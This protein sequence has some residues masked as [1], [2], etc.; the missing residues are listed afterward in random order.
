MTGLTY[1]HSNFKK[2]IYEKRKDVNLNKILFLQNLQLF[3]FQSVSML[4]M[5][6]PFMYNV[7]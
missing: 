3:C 2:Y 7:N 4:N 5:L 1:L 6:C